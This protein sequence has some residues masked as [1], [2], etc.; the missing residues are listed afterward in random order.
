MVL[1]LSTAIL[2]RMELGTHLVSDRFFDSAGFIDQEQV[3][4]I[5]A[6]GSIRKFEKLQNSQPMRAVAK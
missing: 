4:W 5:V 1:Q 3:Q 2:A 6:G